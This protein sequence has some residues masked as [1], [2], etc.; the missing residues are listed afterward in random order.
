MKETLVFVHGMSHGAWCWKEYFIPYFE[1]LGYECLAVNLPGHENPGSKKAIHYSLDAYVEALANTVDCLAEDPIIIGHSMGGMILQK[2]LLKGRCKQAILL[3]S[4][5]PSGV[6]LPSL[7]VLIKHP[8]GIKYL[9][10]ANLLGVFR[11]NP[12]L[13]FGSNVRTVEYAD[14]MCAESFW[15]YLQLMIPLLRIKKGIPMLVM[16]GTEDQLISANEFKQTAKVYGAELMLMDGG[17]H[18]LMLDSD[19]ARYADK[20]YAW[21]QLNP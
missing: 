4:V 3:A 7:R 20:I 5:P 10:Q 14:K 6:L 8:G 19:C 15:A 17:S 12:I 9:F 13:M 1:Q 11:K 16:G 18:D 21:M 2:Y